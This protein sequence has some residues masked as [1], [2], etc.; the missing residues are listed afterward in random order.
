MDQEFFRQRRTGDMITR[1]S[2]DMT[3]VRDSIGQGLLQGIRAAVL[4]VFASVV[5]FLTEPF[6]ALLV[7]ALY[8]PMTF[9]CFFVLRFVRVRQ[10]LLQEQVS[11]IS[12]FCQE[13]FSG[14]KCIKGFAI[15]QRRIGVFESINKKLIKLTMQ[16]Q[17]ARQVFWPFMA[18]WFSVSVIIILNI[19]GKQVINGQRSIGMLVQFL[20]YLLYMQMPL[21]SFSWIASLLQRGKVSWYRIKEILEQE[22]KIKDTNQTDYS[23]EVLHGNIE[24]KNISLEIENRRVLNQVDIFI[25]SGKTIGITGPTGS[26]KTLL[27]SLIARLMDPTEGNIYID[28]HDIKT[29]PLSI[30]RKHIGFAAQESILFSRTLQH[31]I[32]FGVDEPDE[33]LI[34]WAANISDLKKDIDTFSN[35]YET[36]IGERGVTLSGGQRQ[37]TTISRAVMRN[38]EILIFDDVLSAVDTQTESAIMNKLQSVINKKTTIFVSHRASTLRYTDEI[39]VVENGQITQRG[40]HEE[41]IE[42]PGYYQNLNVM[43]QIE[44]TLEGDS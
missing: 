26:G 14:I 4:I 31:N 22:S 2:S 25:P 6:W 28:S 36:M 27:V 12:N 30:L 17:V 3:L 43:Q 18:F 15:E 19:G 44:K 34:E 32:G 21:L 20:Q 1:M 11:D 13:T 42:K 7:L 16:V 24:L 38:P 10:K 40:T 33:Q 39:I 35:R 8:L 29:I 23:I 41:L 9:F 37:R 5:M